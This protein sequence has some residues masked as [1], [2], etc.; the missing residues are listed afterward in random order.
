MKPVFQFSPPPCLSPHLGGSCPIQDCVSLSSSRRFTTRGQSLLKGEAVSLVI[1]EPKARRL[2]SSV[3][4]ELFIYIFFFAKQFLKGSG[5]C[6]KHFLYP[7][8]LNICPICLPENKIVGSSKGVGLKE[9]CG[10]RV[11]AGTVPEH[12]SWEGPSAMG[13]HAPEYLMSWGLTICASGG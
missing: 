3:W 10:A 5:S 12:E 11:G 7:L 9:P 13:G 8:C 1:R 6:W 2:L 4:G